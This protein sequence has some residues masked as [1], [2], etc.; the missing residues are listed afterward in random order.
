MLML[1]RFVA[2]GLLLLALV[3]APATLAAR[4]RRAAARLCNG[5]YPATRNAANPLMVARSNPSDPLRGAKLFV[6]GPR[7]GAAAGAIAK[8]LGRDPAGYPAS[9]SW[10]QFGASLRHGAVARRLEH[11]RRLARSVALL[12]KIAAQPEENR[13]SLYSAGGGTGAIFSQVHK[14]FC[15]TMTADPG[16]VPIITTYFLYQAGYCE[17]APTIRAHRARFERQVNELAAGIGARPAVVLI[18]LDAIGSARCMERMGS[19]GLWEQNLAYEIARIASLP[20]TVAY[21]EGGYS[22]SNSPGWTARALRAVGVSRIRGFFTNDTHNAWTKAEVRWGNAVSHLTGGSHFVINTATN[23]RGPLLNAH[24]ARDGIEYLCNAPGRGLGPAPTARTGLRQV[25]AYLWTGVPGNSAG[26][27][28]GGPPAGTFWS[29]RAIGLAA[30]A[31]NR[32]G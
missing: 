6:D 17:N 5:A 29:A 19:L 10:A 3:F 2:G 14:F 13:F 30:R 28:N 20:H 23:G 8:L 11:N 1:R 15:G 4:H 26:S 12:A 25:D 18:E 24:P 32:I 16:S 27:C 21:V 7:H 22:D 9:E 31:S